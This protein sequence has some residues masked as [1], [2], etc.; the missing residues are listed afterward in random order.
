VFRWVQIPIISRP[1]RL[2]PLPRLLKRQRVTSSALLVAVFMVRVLLL[3]RLVETRRAL[4]LLH[5]MGLRDTRK[6]IPYR[7]RVVVPAR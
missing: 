2:L 1:P 5:G 3:K 4:A 7:R 6:H